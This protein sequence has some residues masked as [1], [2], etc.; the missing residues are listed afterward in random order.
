MKDT[1]KSFVYGSIDRPIYEL[2]PSDGF[3]CFKVTQITA[4]GGAVYQGLVEYDRPLT[5]DETRESG[6]V[7]LTNTTLMPSH[8][9]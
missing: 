5:E 6:L 2:L 7:F 4:S 8:T 1:Q 3:V 9:L